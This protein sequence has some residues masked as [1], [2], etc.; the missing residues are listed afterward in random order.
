MPITRTTEARSRLT[1][2]LF[3]GVCHKETPA[4]FALCLGA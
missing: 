1:K 2:P 4:N 3:A